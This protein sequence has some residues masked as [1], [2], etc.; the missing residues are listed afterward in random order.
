MYLGLRHI[1]CVKK[2]K[3]KV[4]AD[5]DP[6]EYNI[7]VNIHQI[8]PKLGHVCTWAWDILFRSKGQT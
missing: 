8:S 2:S 4:I 1:N 6:G 7:F 3:V 5:N